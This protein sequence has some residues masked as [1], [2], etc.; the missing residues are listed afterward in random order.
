MNKIELGIKLPLYY[1]A[2]SLGNNSPV[3]INMTLALTNRCNSK[4]LTCRKYEMETG[5]ELIPEEWAKIFKHLPMF[6]TTFT[7]GE[8]FL[9]KDITEVYLHLVNLSHPAI[10]NI[11]TNGL[12]EDRVVSKVWE[13]ANMDKSVQ[14]IVNVSL[15][16]WMPYSNDQ[17]RGVKGYFQKATNTLKL[18]QKLDCENLTV[19]IHTVIS[20][21][22][23]KSIDMIAENLS[24]LLINK[25]KSHY[26]TEVAENRVELGTIGLDIT[27]ES[28]DY[29][30]A[31]ESL[32]KDKSLIQSMRNVYYKRV[33]GLLNGKKK[34]VPCFAGYMSGQITADGNV[35]HCC[36]QGKSIGNLRDY[37]YDIKYIWNNHQS[38]I[39]R[40][41]NK[42]CVCPLANA[43]YTN[44]LLHIPTMV[45]VASNM[46]RELV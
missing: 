29:R 5:K 28:S 14:L 20:K 8:P 34:C 15:D 13:M 42:E 30:K 37:G 1:I 32:D 45:K 19:G 44:S 41:E 4:C 27:P 26:I 38:W 43:G 35:W 21:Y 11:P 16:H 6:W 3:P 9:Y 17:I 24:K 33:I 22:N 25:N 18:L 2:R 39:L 36:I 46:V 40:K 7:G 31:I 10:V 12:L 23:V